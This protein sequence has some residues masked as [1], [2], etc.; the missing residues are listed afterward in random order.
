MNVEQVLKTVFVLL[1][2]MALGVLLTGYL[3]LLEVSKLSCGVRMSLGD[4]ALVVE[5]KGEYRVYINGTQ[6]WPRGAGRLAA[7]PLEWQAAEVRVERGSE[8][9]TLYAVRLP[10][11]TYVF[12]WGGKAARSVC[13]P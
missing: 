10:N 2:G 7:I 6:V 12:A 1:A 8:S 4:S 5:G 11:G 9:D 13:I 3:A